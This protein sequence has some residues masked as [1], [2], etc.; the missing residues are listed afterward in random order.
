MNQ[1]FTEEDI[2]MTKICSTSS[3]IREIELKP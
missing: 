2:Q 3:A 1:P